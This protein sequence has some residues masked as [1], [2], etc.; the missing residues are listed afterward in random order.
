MDS[1]RTRR[2]AK[3]AALILL[4]LVLAL[5]NGAVLA[6]QGGGKHHKNVTTVTPKKLHGWGYFNDQADQP[7]TPVFV[8]GPDTP[9]L[10]KGSAQLKIESAAEGEILSANIFLGT[11]LADI[12]SLSYQT[13]VTSHDTAG[14]APSL[15]LGIDFDSTDNVTGFQGRLVF[16][17]DE[18]GNR[19]NLGE[20]QEWN[21]LDN[22]QS[23]G[24]GTWFFTKN[25]PV[26]A[27]PCPQSNKCTWTEVLDA[28]PNITIHPTGGDGSNAGL[29]FIGFK[30]GSGEG[31]VD[32]NVDDLSIQFDGQN[33]PNVFD[34][35]SKSKKK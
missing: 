26:G 5:G 20:W 1:S 6:K 15:Q 19:V 33:K 17:P 11:P 3:V 21:P 24:G 12:T 34:F 31:A 23:G 27:N 22:A 2:G 25:P 32:A 7:L 13:F 30:V 28:F 35:E 18:F 8:Q 9:P 4:A 29:G 14:V 16:V 10:G